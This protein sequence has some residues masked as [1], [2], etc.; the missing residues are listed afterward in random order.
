M[1]GIKDLMDLSGRRA[2]VS[3]AAGHIGHEICDTLSELGAEIIAVDINREGLQYLKESI[4]TKNGTDVET[5]TCDISDAKKRI[6]LID[7]LNKK[8]NFLNILINN[9][10]L[11]GSVFD[12]HESDEVGDHDL[13]EWHRT[14]A[15]NLTPAYDFSIKLSPLISKSTGGNII[16]ISSIYGS[17]APNF[18][19]YEG[20][21]MDN[22]APY[23]V[24]KAGLNQLTLWLSTK[25][26][27]E[28]R[29]NAISPGGIY[30]SQPEI[31][32]RRYINRTPLGRMGSE[33]DIKG[34]IAYLAS[35]LSNYVTG[36][37]LYVDG[38]W[39]AY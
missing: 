38:G 26:A 18:S 9:A 34:A 30:R 2:L 15:I 23:G 16:N 6:D 3:G 19:L 7:Y 22:P 37:N 17:C 39:S 14:L 24:S 11:T 29:V 33:E 12:K 31:F 13:S 25:L 5:I 10:A 1:R 4:K 8:Y 21:E 27:P 36:H 35:D 32:I 28:I 20:T